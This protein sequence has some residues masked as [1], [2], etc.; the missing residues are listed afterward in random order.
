MMAEPTPKRP[1]KKK[2]IMARSAELFRTRGYSAT[3]MRDI[4]DAVGIEAASLYNHIS[5]KTDL[6]R[7]IIFGIASHCNEHL[8][9]L[10]QSPKTPG[11]KI[12]ELIRFH[13]RLM[14]NRYDEYSVMTRDW[15]HLNE[16]HL[17]E[18]ARQRRSYVQQMEQIVSDGIASGEFKGNI[19]KKLAVMT[20]FS[21][22]NWMPQWYDPSGKIDPQLGS[23]LADMLVNGLKK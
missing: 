7:E 14:I 2:I 23:Q 5:A 9:E 17:P 6:L 3:S 20:L 19:D 8:E 10:R 21:S 1:S 4:A 13:V 22:L 15:N 18:F 16:T 11:E 12:E